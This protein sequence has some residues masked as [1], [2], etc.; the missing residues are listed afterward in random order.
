MSYSS[1]QIWSFRIENKSVGLFDIFPGGETRKFIE[2]RV[3]LE[4]SPKIFETSVEKNVEAALIQRHLLENASSS[5]FPVGSVEPLD[6]VKIDETQRLIFGHFLENIDFSVGTTEFQFD[7]RFL[8]AEQR[9]QPRR[10]VDRLD[11]DQICFV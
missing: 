3:P 6:P 5:E 2:S 9:F 4:N 7:V 1:F 10:K 8:S 11:F